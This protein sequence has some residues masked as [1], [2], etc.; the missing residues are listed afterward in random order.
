MREYKKLNNQ[1]LVFVLAAFS[2]S[3]VLEMDKY[4]PA[5]QEKLRGKLPN[6]RETQTQEV[7]VSPTGIKINAQPNW[8]FIAKDNQSAA[9]INQ[10]RLLFV[11]SQYK[12]FD[13]FQESCDFLLEQLID[14]VSP[15]LFTQLGLRY[16]DTI[17]DIDGVQAEDFVKKGLFSSSELDAVG[18]SV[19]QTSE[20][21][22]KTAEGAMFVRSLYGVSNLLVVPDAENLP[23]KIETVSNAESNRVLL[24]FDHIWDAQE[25]GE[26]VE[27]DKAAI[28]EKL[29]A[30]HELSRLAFWDITT[31]KA[32]EVW[33]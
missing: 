9:I 14:V 21:L 25:E 8:E 2:F 3:P 33:Q 7:E 32:K 23:I 20:I 28:L 15:N 16:T 31:D 10:N 4:I 27:F 19:R 1:P 5:I 22:L 26:A 30:M 12:R 11:T 17:M 6:F 13:D 24:D 29:S 18:S